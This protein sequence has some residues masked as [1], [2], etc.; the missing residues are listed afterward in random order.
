MTA[1]DATFRGVR[2]AAILAV[3][4]VASLMVL[5]MQDAASQPPP[6]DGPV[7]QWIR[8]GM[9]WHQLHVA[10]DVNAIVTQEEFDHVM[11]KAQKIVR[12]PKFPGNEYDYSNYQSNRLRDQHFSPPYWV[13]IVG[14]SAIALSLFSWLYG[15]TWATDVRCEKAVARPRMEQ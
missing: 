4:A 13:G 10:E 3:L 5:M 9:E 6:V 14:F 12:H 7:E 8:V 15:A 2:L 11:K 1:T